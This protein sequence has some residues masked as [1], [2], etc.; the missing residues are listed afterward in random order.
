MLRQAFE[1]EMSHPPTQNRKDRK[2]SNKAYGSRHKICLYP[3]TLLHI[4]LPVSLPPKDDKA[5]SA[6]A[7]H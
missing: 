7:L 6:Q 4:Y 2:N 5:F 3:Q 1:E